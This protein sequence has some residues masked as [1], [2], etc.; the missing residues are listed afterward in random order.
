MCPV[1]VSPLFIHLF[2]CK[3]MDSYSDMFWSKICVPS[4]TESGGLFACYIFYLN[5]HFQTTVNDRISP[6]FRIAPLSIKPPGVKAI[7]R[8][9]PPFRL[10]PQGG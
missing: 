3:Y 5:C 1:F 6:Q 9:K 2:C 10:S 7:L 4:I 8:N